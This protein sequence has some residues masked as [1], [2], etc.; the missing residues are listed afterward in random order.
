[1]KKI[2]TTII[3]SL[4]LIMKVSSQDEKQIASKDGVNVSYQIILEEESKKKDKYILIVNYENVSDQDLYYEVQLTKDSE[5]Q[6]SLPIIPEEKAFTKIKVRNSTGLFGDGQ[7]LIGDATDLITTSNTL[8][9]E[10]KQGDVSSQETT[11]K[12]KSGVKPLITNTYLKSIK[13]IDEFDL[14]ISSKMLNGDYISSCGNLK[15]NINSGNSEEDG[16][17]LLQTTNGK[18]FI[19]LR[20]SETTFTRKNNSDYTLTFN[21]HNNTFTYATSDGITCSWDKN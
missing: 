20:S 1:M 4:L 9:F 18:Q 15:I 6:L 7:S 16:D 21:K 5:G 13:S 3:L 14:K 11:F 19:W 10:L 2:T 17:Y 8:L 12:V